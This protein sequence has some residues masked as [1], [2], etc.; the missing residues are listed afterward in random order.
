M[1]WLRAWTKALARE[2]QATRCL[3]WLVDRAFTL[4]GRSSVSNAPFPPPRYI[5]ST[6]AHDRRRLTPHLLPLTFLAASVLI[7][8]FFKPQKKILQGK[9]E[10]VMRLTAQRNSAK[11]R[12]DSL[13][14]DLSRVCGGGRTLDQIEVIVTK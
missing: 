3:L 13:A 9:T 10:E 1:L 12:A 8:C 11:S 6:R 7:S 14:K 5:R 4:L 2:A